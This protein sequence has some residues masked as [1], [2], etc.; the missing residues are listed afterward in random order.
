[1]SIRTLFSK[2][3][4][5]KFVYSHYKVVKNNQYFMYEGRKYQRLDGT[6]ACTTSY[7]TML[8]V[9]NPQDIVLAIYY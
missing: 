5:R 1:M 7:P 9:F 3:I 2:L 8:K 4:R 6:R